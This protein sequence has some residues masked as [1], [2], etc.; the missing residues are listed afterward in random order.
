ME[1]FVQE[2]ENQK[3]D[4]ED[5]FDYNQ[6]YFYNRVFIDPDLMEDEDKRNPMG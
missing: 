6:G 3:S 5:S 2:A 4:Y 1:E